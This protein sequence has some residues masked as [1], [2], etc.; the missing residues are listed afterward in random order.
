MVGVP[1]SRPLGAWGQAPNQSLPQQQG[2]LPS[3]K[4]RWS[5][6]CAN[7]EDWN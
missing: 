4:L 5:E 7:P 3:R 6:A 1:C 2:A